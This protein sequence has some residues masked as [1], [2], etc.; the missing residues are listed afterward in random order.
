MKLNW[1]I[2]KDVFILQQQEYSQ[3]L[4]ITLNEE[5]SIKIFSPYVAHLKVIE[6]VKSSTPQ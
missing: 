6:Y 2:K 1:K 4:I 5:Q 3:Y